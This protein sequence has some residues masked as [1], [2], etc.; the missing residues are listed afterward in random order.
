MKWLIAVLA[1]V[2]MG[3]AC[4]GGNESRDLFVRNNEMGGLIAFHSDR[5]GDFEIFVMNPDGTEVRQLTDNDDMDAGPVWSPD[6][7]RI[8]FVSDRAGDGEVYVMNADGTE[9]RQLTNNTNG[10]SGDP[11]WSPDGTHIAY[12]SYIGGDKEIFVRGTEYGGQI[13]QLTDNDDADQSPAWSPDG[14][15]IAF[16]SNRDSHPWDIFVM[17]ADGSKVRQLTNIDHGEEWGVWPFS[18]D[19]GS[20]AWSPDG[21]LI[22]FTSET[23]PFHDDLFEMNADGTE[24]FPLS[25]KDLGPSHSPAWSPDGSLLVFTTDGDGTEIVVMNMDDGKVYATGQEGSSPSWGG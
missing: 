23:E 21:T 8:A 12:T 3:A 15:L 17:N 18:G 5:A 22:A 24:V 25:D 11:S 1:C 4:G 2:A 14:T 9:V 13:R 6:D 10:W 19:S 16:S 20:P 7:T